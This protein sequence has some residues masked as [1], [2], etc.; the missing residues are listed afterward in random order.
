VRAKNLQADQLNRYRADPLNRQRRRF[1]VYRNKP[2][3]DC[4]RRVGAGCLIPPTVYQ[5]PYPAFVSAIAEPVN[6]EL[7]R[8]ALV[9][10]RR[11]QYLGVVQE[12]LLLAERVLPAQSDDIVTTVSL[13]LFLSLSLSPC[14]RREPDRVNSV[15]L[16]SISRSREIFKLL[17]CSR[18]TKK[19]E[20]KKGKKEK[21][22]DVKIRKMEK[23]EASRS[24]TGSFGGKKKS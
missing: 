22:S 17:V 9:E 21:N 8:P 6:D 15:A 3:P 19:E 13:S 23:Q 4:P 12:Q 7:G 2:D 1:R 14:S 18:R 16:I 24:P 20:E 10:V 11:V 5:I